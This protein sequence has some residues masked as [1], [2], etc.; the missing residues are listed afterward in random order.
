LPA[1]SRETVIS[2][3]AR[4]STTGAGEPDGQALSVVLSAGEREGVGEGLTARPYGDG[5]V[6]GLAGGGQAH[7]PFGG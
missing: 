7:R 3:C 2:S 4:G 6:H 5:H 1:A